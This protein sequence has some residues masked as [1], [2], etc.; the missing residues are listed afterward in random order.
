M[1]SHVESDKSLFSLLAQNDDESAAMAILA[2]LCRESPELRHWL[3]EDFGRDAKARAMF[4]Q[5]LDDPAAPPV[6]RFVELTSDGAAWREMRQKLQAQVPA[7]IYGG[8]TWNEVVQLVRH[9]QAGRIDLGAFLLAQEWRKAGKSSPLLTLASTELLG[10]VIPSG[11]RRLLR[12]LEKALAFLKG[13]ENKARRRNLLGYGNRWKMLVLL[14]MLR[15]PCGCYPIRELCDYVA[16]LGFK[17]S[18]L[19]MRRFCVHHGIRRDNRAGRPPK[20]PG[21]KGTPKYFNPTGT[22]KKQTGGGP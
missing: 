6:G 22:R 15:H 4:A 20:P 1:K 13:Y 7:G 8:L 19:E 16:S 14:Y 21:A 18:P 2:Q 10:K 3:W 9:Y 5:L 11:R 17:I 12:H